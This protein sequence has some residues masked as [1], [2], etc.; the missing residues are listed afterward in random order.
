VAASLALLTRVIE[1]TG[2]G[3]R[4]GAAALIEKLDAK[5]ALLRSFFRDL[6]AS[7][8]STA[9]PSASPAVAKGR[10]AHLRNLRLR[11]SFLELALLGS[12]LQ[13]SRDQLDGLWDLLVSGGDEERALFFAFLDALADREGAFV[14]MDDSLVNY[15]FQDKICSLDP[16]RV[17]P[18]VWFFSLSLSL[19][20]H[21]TY[22]VRYLI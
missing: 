15:L 10:E 3:K 5:H 17:G 9:A 12:G 14:A 20:L 4:K 11:L 16:A 2:R 21:I 7:A 18:D 8:S 1:M 13:L 22:V 6:R 19:S